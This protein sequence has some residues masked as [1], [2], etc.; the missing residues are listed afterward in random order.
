M[1]MVKESTDTEDD[2]VCAL[3]DHGAAAVDAMRNSDFQDVVQAAGLAAYHIDYGTGE[4]RLSPALIA[5][6]GGAL[7][8]PL[9]IADGCPVW[10]HPQDRARVLKGLHIACSAGHSGDFEQEYRILREDG[11]ECWVLDKGRVFSLQDTSNAAHQQSG[12]RRP[13]K[14]AGVL[15]DI[16][17]R[18]VSEQQQTAELEARVRELNCLYAVSRLVQQQ[19]DLATLFTQVVQLV[20]T[21]FA[22]SGR[23]CAR[24]RYQDQLYSAS[25]FN[26]STMV[27]CQPLTVAG[28][29]VGH[30]ELHRVDMPTEPAAPFRK[31]EQDLIRALAK[32][33]IR[34]IERAQVLQ[35]LRESEDLWR[36]M[37]EALAEGVVLHDGAGRI[38]AWNPSAERL[39]S[40]TSEEM[41]GKVCEDPIWQVIREDGSVFPGNEH[42]AMYSL[43]T[44]QPCDEMIMG[45]V[46]TDGQ[47]TWI[48]ANSRP[49]RHAEGEQPYAV[50]VSFSDITERRRAEEALRRE[51]EAKELERLRLRTVLEALPLGVYIAEADGRLR[52]V[53]AAAHALWG[54][55]PLS[56][57][58]LSYG[59]DYPA[60]WPDS[61]QPVGADE[62]GLARALRTGETVIGEEM[63]FARFDGRRG[64]LLNYA[65]PIRDDKGRIAGGVAVNVDITERNDSD[66]EQAMLAAIV[67]TTLDAI[68]STDTNGIIISW[69]AGAEQ[70]YGYS[71]AEAISQ[72]IRMIVPPDRTA[73]V[74][75]SLAKLREGRRIDAYDTV[76][77]RKDG[78]LVHISVSIAPLF[79]ASGR[80]IGMAAVARDVTQRKQNEER[81]SLLA[82]IVEMSSDAMFSC[83]AEL[84]LQSWNKGAEA[85][86]GYKAEEVIGR[87]LLCLVP[88]DRHKET[89]EALAQI[90]RGQ[91]VAHF[92]TERRHRCGRLVPVS[93][94]VSPIFDKEGR[95]RGA[96]A[97]AH[98]ISKRKRM[99]EQLHRSAFYDTLTGVANRSLFMDRLGHVIARAER[100]GQRYA[101]V[102]MDMDNFKLIN[103]SFGHLV[104]DQLLCAFVARVQELLR[105]V[106]TL[107]RFGGDEFT[108]LLEDT[109]SAAAV[110][111]VAERILAA[112]QKP[113]QL[114]SQ[115]VVVSS[116]MGITL[117]DAS[118]TCSD[119]ALRDADV[120]LYE[121]KRRGKNQFVLFDA[122]MR[123]EEV[124]RLYLEAELRRALL[125]T[126]LAVEYQPI[127]DVQSDVLVG[128]E[129]LARWNHSTMGRVE[130]GRFIN[131]AE[132]TGLITPLGRFVLERAA[133]A[134]AGWLRDPRVPA[135]FYVSVNVSPKEFYAG[136]LVPFVQSVLNR[137]QLKGSHLRLEI[138]ESVVIQHDREAANILLALQ[139]MGV[140]VCMDDFGT[141]YSSLSYLHQLPFNVIKVDRSFIQSL[142]AKKQSREIVRSIVRLARA[143]DMQSIAEGAENEEQLAHAKALGFRWVQGY[144]LY[145]PMSRQELALLLAE[146]A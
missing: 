31:E 42:P 121:A 127:V 96:A 101:V 33:L 111:E 132:D 39:L 58:L 14:G 130:P 114:E 134:L 63:E 142:A 97:V 84:R 126:E 22:E 53:N 141:G 5:L 139:A 20:P 57:S 10:V 12:G 18:K 56:D 48:S 28:Q 112:L 46:R 118:Y 128:C 17:E 120:A 94:A 75:S 89:H 124:S 116:S 71:A 35:A 117:G 143:L 129:A 125:A 64:T 87:N 40:R 19:E 60:W 11:R 45:L 21:G 30:L 52:D 34:V 7:P 15:L 115:E 73:E 77:V 32:P 54:K 16:T 105:P 67:E 113:F 92:D 37:T 2:A 6:V 93:L 68:V 86:L 43:T 140:Q 131:V 69:N 3:A 29:E 145:K 85:L 137:Y 99:E 66:R 104:G 108:L 24:I 51:V 47:V 49:L 74:E 98:D 9:V 106:D 95:V 65:M 123:G 26:A 62:W 79:H 59:E 107:A 91:R 23:T 36:T 136:D 80:I 44:G 103:D 55:A 83:D 72:S 146:P 27:L 41:H 138:T 119:Q 110:E 144:A 76:R 61:G 122:R 4:V 82:T 90:L 8:F 70:L 1:D 78:S 38:V 102:V 109:E 133:Q 100:F 88:Q 81:M 13:C 50:V 25:A 135:N